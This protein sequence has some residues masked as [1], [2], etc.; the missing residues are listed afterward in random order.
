M[1]DKLDE[2][3][4]VAAERA[5]TIRELNAHIAYLES[6][7]DRLEDDLGALH[8]EGGGAGAAA[9][10]DLATLCEEGRSWRPAAAAE[11]EAVRRGVNKTAR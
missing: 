6:R 10:D 7:I 11:V 2:M 9:A 4:E 1:G 5:S 3:R 8:A